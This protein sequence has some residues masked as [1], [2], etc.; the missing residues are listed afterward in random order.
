MREP[1]SGIRFR[2]KDLLFAVCV[3]CTLWLIVQNSLLFALGWIGP[4]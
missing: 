2:G 3:V 1:D 4:R